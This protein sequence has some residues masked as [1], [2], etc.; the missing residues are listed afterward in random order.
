MEE[1]KANKEGTIGNEKSIHSLYIY[2]GPLHGCYRISYPLGFGEDLF[3]FSEGVGARFDGTHASGCFST[4]HG[5]RREG[6]STGNSQGGDSKSEL[7]F[8]FLLNTIIVEEKAAIL[9]KVWYYLQLWA[10]E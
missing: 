10:D 4:S 6:G 1:G 8:D 9:R 2:T 5:T 3:G 7:H